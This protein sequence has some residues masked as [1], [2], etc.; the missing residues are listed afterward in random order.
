MVGGRHELGHDATACWRKHTRSIDKIRS[1]R[2]GSFVER[3]RLCCWSW[4]P[5]CHGSIR[6]VIHGPHAL[7]IFIKLTPGLS[8]RSSSFKDTVQVHRG[9]LKLMRQ[10]QRSGLAGCLC[11]TIVSL[12]LQ[13]QDGAHSPALLATL[14]GLSFFVG[15]VVPIL[16]SWVLWPFVARHELRVALSSTM[17]FMSILYQ[18]TYKTVA[19]HP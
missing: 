9:A 17:I 3:R 6:R 11:F 7:P 19:Q 4:K 12:G 15:I 1:R 2:S 14:K 5:L 8:L 18:S 13:A 10:F 16:A